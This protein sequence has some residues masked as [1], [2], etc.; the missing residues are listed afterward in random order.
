MGPSYPL[1]HAPATAHAYRETTSAAL[2][3]VEEILLALQEDRPGFL[4]DLQP[5]L[6]VETVSSYEES[7]G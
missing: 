2:D 5:L 4:D 3:R 7:Q 6:M 1:L